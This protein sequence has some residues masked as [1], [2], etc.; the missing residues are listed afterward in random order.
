MNG[1]AVWRHPKPRDAAGRC[2]GRSDLRVDRR[3]A[4]RLAHR[5]RA[6]ARQHRAPR[7]VT[8]S[9]LRRAADVGRWLARWGWEHRIDPRLDELDFGTWEGRPWND[10]GAVAVE[11]WCVDFVRHAPGG[12]EPV[13]M[14]L[15]RCA[16]FLQEAPG[17][18]VS[19]AGWI[20]A[21]CWWLEHTGEPTAAQWPAALGY[22]ELKAWSAPAASASSPAGSACS[23]PTARRERYR[24]TSR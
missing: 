12:G 6:W 10:I 15:Q 16:A 1:W 14:L 17:C 20:S 22:G 7:V 5:V 23:S 8:T 24:P 9:T 21:A 19:H 2:I 13:A 18:V 11:A 3:K 4:K